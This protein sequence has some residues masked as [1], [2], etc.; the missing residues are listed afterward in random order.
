[1]LRRLVARRSADS[2]ALARSRFNGTVEHTFVQNTPVVLMRGSNDSAAEAG[3]DMVYIASQWTSCPGRSLGRRQPGPGTTA[4]PRSQG[5]G[6]LARSRRGDHSADS[7]AR[8]RG[9][10][11]QRWSGSARALARSGRQVRGVLFRGCATHR[12]ARLAT[13]SRLARLRRS[14]PHHDRQLDFGGRHDHPCTPDRDEPHATRPGH[15]RL[16]RTTRIRCPSR[17][18][19]GHGILRS[20]RRADH[21]DPPGRRR[22]G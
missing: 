16:G 22:Q 10:E 21:Q 1:M 11:R 5:D 14:H 13:A 6:S 17:V 15:G 19:A 20:F 8:G 2:I 4:T 7:G 18:R 12:P 9:Q 3:H